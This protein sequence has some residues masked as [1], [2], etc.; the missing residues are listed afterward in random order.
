MTKS[1]SL[2]DARRSKIAP[3]ENPIREDFHVVVY[4]DKYPVTDGHLLFVPQHV[5]DRLIYDCFHDA[6]EYGKK[7][8]NNGKWDGF[9]IGLNWGKAAGQTVDYPHIHLIP[10]RTGDVRDPRGGVRNVIPDKGNY[11]VDLSK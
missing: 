11:Q 1:Y 6:L 2:A 10:R 8:V 5:E 3:W 4:Q 9:N 7:M